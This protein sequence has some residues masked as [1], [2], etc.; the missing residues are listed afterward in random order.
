ME[1]SEHKTEQDTQ[2][3]EHNEHEASEKKE[4][5]RIRLP[6]PSFSKNSLTTY[7]KK[8]WPVIAII[9]IMILGMQVRLLDYRWPYLR[10]IDSYAFARQ[11][12]EVAT[13]GSL[14]PYDEIGLAPVTVPRLLGH[15]FYVY[16]GGYTFLLFK[17]FMPALT[18]FEFLIFFPAFFASLM[19]IP[20]YFI[21]SRLFD[22]RAGVLAAFFM[23]FDISVMSRTL[24]GDPDSDAAVLFVPLV[25]IAFFLLAYKYA[26]AAKKINK[27]YVIYTVL[28]GLALAM[29][30]FTWGGYWYVVWLITGFVV[31]RVIL[32]FL[33]TKDVRKNFEESKHTLIVFASTVAIFFLLTVPVFGLNFIPSTILGPFQ[34]GDIK[35]EENTEFPNVYVSVAELQASGSIRDV[36]QRTSPI[37][38]SE[39]P[40]LM[41]VTPFFLMIYGLVYLGFSYYKTKKHLDTLVLLLIWFIG[42]FIA[43]IIAVRFSILFSAPIAIGSAIFLSKLIRVVRYREGFGD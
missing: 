19:A 29:W 17:L 20:M 10:N 30:G 23:V 12:E 18:M 4:K 38:F 7:L 16:F 36:I 42:P 40:F 6:V 26:N 5:V 27:R 2:K 31:L 1:G 9:T 25:A 14:L 22:R 3:E 37:N 35:S 39:N 13:Y 24:G 33:K 34:F 41:L 11:I 15:D 21:G 43:T 8:Y 28:S 32:N